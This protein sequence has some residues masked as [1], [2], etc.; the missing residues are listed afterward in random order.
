MQ[1]L[2]NS[3]E[4]KRI[5]ERVAKM[6]G[7]A[8]ECEHCRSIDAKTYDW[9]NV[10]GAYTLQRSDWKRL[11]RSCHVRM[12]ASIRT[13]EFEL[14][15]KR[16]NLAAWAREVGIPYRTVRTRIKV[17]GWDVEQAL[18]TRV[19]ERTRWKQPQREVRNEDS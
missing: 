2:V 14:R 4:Y 6:F 13:D 9:A 5:H 8:R 17:C 10:S 11:C 18:F 3:R 15:G 16:M 19:G 1:I 12:D 7:K